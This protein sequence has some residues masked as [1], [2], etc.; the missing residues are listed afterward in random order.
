VSNREVVLAPAAAADLNGLYDY[1]AAQS[2][3]GRALAYIGRLEKYCAG[4]ALMAER[5]TMR[6]DIRAGL[7][8][9][10][11]ERRV[12]IAFHVEPR[13]G[14]INRIL[15]AGRDFEKA[16]IAPDNNEN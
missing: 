9:I 14:V 16:L 3:P 12:T 10:G 8:T 4:F 7:R 13:R 5:G 2:S 1:I 6:D 15:Y 11:F